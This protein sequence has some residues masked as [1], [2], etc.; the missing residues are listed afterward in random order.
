MM[1]ILALLACAP[2]T[3]GGETDTQ[4][5]ATH[6]TA[7][8]PQTYVWEFDCDADPPEWSPPAGTIVGLQFFTLLNSSLI[9]QQEDILI[10]PG[11]TMPEVNWGDPI[12]LCS[13]GGMT[14]GRLVLTYLPA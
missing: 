1:M 7:S 12:D 2:E 14:G 5:E 4:I 3:S 9:A 11:Q 6:T 13:N 10:E 8:G